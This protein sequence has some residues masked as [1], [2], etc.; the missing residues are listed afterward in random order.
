MELLKFCRKKRNIVIYGAGHY[1][2]IVRCFLFENG[3][4]ISYFV[5]TEEPQD[6]EILEAKVLRASDVCD[7]TSK[8]TGVIICGNSNICNEMCANIKKMGVKNYYVVKEA[9]LKVIDDKTNYSKTFRSGKKKILLY[10]RIGF[11]DCDIWNMFTSPDNFRNQLL[12]LKNKYQIVKFEDMDFNSNQE[13]VAITIDDGYVDAYTMVMPIACEC[14]VPVTIFVSTGNIDTNNEFWWDVIERA[15]VHNSSCPREIFWDGVLLR[16]KTQCEK[17]VACWGIWK[18]MLMVNE[19]QRIE[20]LSDLIAVTKDDGRNRREYRTV[21]NQELIELD[22]C[23]WITIGSHTVSHTRLSSLSQNEQEVEII[24]SKEKLECILNHKI[25]SMSF[26]FGC[27]DDYDM[28]TIDIVKSAGFDRAASVE[29]N[30]R[31]DF[32]R[33]NMP[34]ISLSDLNSD[35]R[36]LRRALTLNGSK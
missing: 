25:S 8:E 27:Q 22:K 16:L 28:R 36:A 13:E 24:N 31:G 7:I 3:I 14:E 33:Y 9:E 5:I 19:Q 17:N 23:P 32:D 2:K 18:K 26:P 1:G 34:R 20:M 21:N 35:L 11:T 12:Y 6:S 4:D 29:M 30:Y 10:H 15:I